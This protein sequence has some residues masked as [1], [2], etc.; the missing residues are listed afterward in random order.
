MLFVKEC[1]VSGA[2]LV[3]TFSK[4]LVVRYVE[5][6]YRVPLKTPTCLCINT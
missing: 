2:V 4:R 1:V 6:F 3:C 5:L